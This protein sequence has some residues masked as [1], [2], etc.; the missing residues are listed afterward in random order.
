MIDMA[1]MIYYLSLGSNLGD[2]R[3]YLK[4][5]V[6]FLKGRGT[7]QKMSAVYETSPVFMTPGASDFLNQVVCLKSDDSPPELLRLI[8][9]F[10]KSM[11]R[12]IERSHNKNRTID[13]DILLANRSIYNSP[14]LTVPHPK[15]ADRAFVL[16]PLAEIAPRLRHPVLRQTIGEILKS[17]KITDKVK[18]VP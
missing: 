7:L 9:E 6:A 15:M 10:E 13:I 3:S 1:G 17:L 12:D 4:R 8:K 2:R 18:R 11:G 16:I 14:A 5:A